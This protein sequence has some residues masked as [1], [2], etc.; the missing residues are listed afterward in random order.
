M[1]DSARA[2][3]TDVMADQYPY[4]ASHTG[5]GVLIPAWAREGGDSAFARRVADPRLRDSILAGT[6]FNIEH[7]RGGGDLR[8]VQFS[9][10]RWQPDLQG[11]TLYDWAVDRGL[12]PLLRTGPNW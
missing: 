11:R 8:R 7:D 3:G 4:T 1:I 12:D 9:S 6:V 2:A 5:L 10:V